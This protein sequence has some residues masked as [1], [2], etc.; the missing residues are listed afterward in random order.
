MGFRGWHVLPSAMT[1]AAA[2]CQ[3]V[4]HKGSKTASSPELHLQELPCPSSP[5]HSVL[6]SSQAHW[7]HWVGHK[8][9][10]SWDWPGKDSSSPHYSNLY[11]FSI[12]I[13]QP[14]CHPERKISM[15]LNKVICLRIAKRVWNLHLYAV[16]CAWGRVK[17]QNKK[18]TYERPREQGYP[19]DME[20]NKIQKEREEKGKQLRGL[21]LN[22]IEK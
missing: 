3:G 11:Y 21:C 1:C 16:I 15:L 12:R 10:D 9:A 4:F 17:K 2:V 20:V 6:V 8:A 5:C 19:T 22:S 13:T 14:N 7:E 18:T